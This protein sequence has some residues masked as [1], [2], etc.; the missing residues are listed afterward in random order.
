MAKVLKE[1]IGNSKLT[2]LQAKL[3]IKEL[4][5]SALLD[6]TNSINSHF[7]TTRKI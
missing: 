1:D 7:S 5:L 6:I 4:Q 3:H 2:H